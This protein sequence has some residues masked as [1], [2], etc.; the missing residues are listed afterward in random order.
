MSILSERERVCVKA[1]KSILFFLVME[2]NLFS[3]KLGSLKERTEKLQICRREQKVKNIRPDYLCITLNLIDDWLKSSLAKQERPYTNYC[4]LRG[5]DSIS[6]CQR[7]FEITMKLTPHHALS[8]PSFIQ[9][10][11][12][13]VNEILSFC[14]LI[15]K[16]EN[17]I[18]IEL[19]DFLSSL[20]YFTSEKDS[21]LTPFPCF[22]LCW[23][24]SHE[25]CFTL[26]WLVYFNYYSD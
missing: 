8:L 12:C 17:S 10:I 9:F 14:F 7:I 1:A 24:Q 19:I 11:N 5:L 20:D 6:E 13:G 22:S 25:I 3:E 21:D 15:I 4:Y 16:I 2:G 23:Y 26:L 18:K